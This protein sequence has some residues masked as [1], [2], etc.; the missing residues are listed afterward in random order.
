LAGRRAPLAER[1]KRSARI[2]VRRPPPSQHADRVGLVASISKGNRTQPTGRLAT[3]R[4]CWSGCEEMGGCTSSMVASSSQHA[5]RVG[6]VARPSAARACRRGG[7]RNTQTVLVWLRGGL[8]RE[9]DCRQD[10]RNTQTVLVWLRGPGTSGGRQPGRARNTQTVLVWLRAGGAL[11]PRARRC[12]TRNTQTVLVWLREP[13]SG[14]GHAAV[15]P[16]NTQTV[17]VWLRA[18]D[19]G[20]EAAAR[21]L[22]TRRPCWSGCESS[23]RRNLRCPRSPRNTQTVLV[24]E[25]RHSDIMTRGFRQDW[26]P[27]ACNALHTPAAPG[28]APA[29]AYPPGPR[30]GPGQA[31]RTAVR[32]ESARGAHR[33]PGSD[34]GAPVMS[35][36]LL[37]V[38][39][40]PLAVGAP[41]RDSDGRAVDVSHGILLSAVRP[42]GAGARIGRHPHWR[43]RGR[44]SGR[45]MLTSWRVPTR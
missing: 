20:R 40:C 1:G 4:P 3:R 34:A 14:R 36:R 23:D 11:Q 17:L 27:P 22:A 44:R 12:R 5:D 24:C 25:N 2:W 19:A 26:P 7:A 39:H 43:H 31:A 15:A 18:P 9:P 37:R 30:R 45:K 13:G 32:P 10:T 33:G 41:L 29:G 38:G 28:D 6:L 16:R 21:A 35:R 42:D 8:Y